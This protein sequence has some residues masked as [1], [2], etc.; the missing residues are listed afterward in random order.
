MK[1]CTPPSLLFK[2]FPAVFAEYLQYARSLSFAQ[3]PD[4]E[5]L[6]T[7]FVQFFKLTFK[8][9]KMLFDWSHLKG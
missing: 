5:M 3:K 2:E 6:R 7:A 8:G 4:Y 9:Q 1:R